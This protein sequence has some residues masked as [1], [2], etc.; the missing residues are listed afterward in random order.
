MRN[1]QLVLV[2]SASLSESQRKKTTETIKKWLKD[3]KIYKEEEIGQKALAYAIKRENAGYYLRLY[4][5]SETIPSDFEKNLYNEDGI[6]RHLL[7]K[8][9]VRSVK[10][11][12]DK[13]KS[14]SSHKASKDKKKKN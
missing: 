3:V 13:K 11:A 8:T 1:Y 12:E 9:K 2:L 10:K 5:E 4:L 14:P 6:L 7:L